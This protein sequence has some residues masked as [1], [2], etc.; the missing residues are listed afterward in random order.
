MK[1][2]KKYQIH[3]GIYH[4]LQ[5]DFAYNSNH[6]E[7]SKLTHDQTKYIFD[8]KTVG[9]VP[10]KVDDIIETVNH[11]RLFDYVI[12]TMDEELTEDYIKH[13]HY[14]LKNATFSSESM[15]AVIGDY[16]KYPNEVSNIETALPSDVGTKMKKLL[17]S[18]NEKNIVS[19]ED[20]VGFHADFEKIHPFYDG[21]GRVGRILI[22]K[23]CLKND[24]IPFY[25]DDK[26]KF[27]YY[28][29][30]KEWQNDGDKTY[31]RETCLFMQDHMKK[32]FDYFQIDYQK[33]GGEGGDDGD[34]DGTESFGS[35]S[36]KKTESERDDDDFSP[37]SDASVST[38]NNSG[39]ETGESDKTDGDT[40]NCSNIVIS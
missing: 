32:I 21:N 26:Y 12:E 4:A 10:A 39:K 29:G 3:G 23:E 28:R 20:I 15:E 1:D 9:I 33:Q 14:I 2:E 25:I 30:L 37:I 5:V 24:I 11:F 31:L 19:F 35:S 18:Y 7:G 22:L 16:K 8:T 6:I 36:E 34:A 27:E 17:H 38:D 13:L 40:R